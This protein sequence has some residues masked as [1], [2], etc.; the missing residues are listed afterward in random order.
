VQ[1]GRQPQQG[2]IGRRAQM[3]L[4]FVLPSGR[5]K[6]LFVRDSGVV[7]HT[8]SE[9]Q[10]IVQFLLRSGFERISQSAK[11][12]ACFTL[13]IKDETLFVWS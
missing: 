5:G 8:L 7:M 4:F 3:L 12:V 11:S 1:G 10:E 6:K 2:F 9:H 13:R